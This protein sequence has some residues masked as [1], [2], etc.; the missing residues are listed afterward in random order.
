MKSLILT[1]FSRNAAA[2]PA[3]TMMTPPTKQGSKKGLLSI[4]STQ[5]SSNCS[6]V[7]YAYVL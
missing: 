6:L 2:R 7:K 4:K 5:V 1:S 3:M